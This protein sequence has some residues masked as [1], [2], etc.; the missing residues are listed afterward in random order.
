[1]DTDSS[2]EKTLPAL[3]PIANKKPHDEEKCG[4]KA[5]DEL[6]VSNGTESS[7]EHWNN[8]KINTWRFLATLWSF[9]MMGANDG[10]FGV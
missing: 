7:L 10:A 2:Q 1:M 4:M 5:E 9:W 3:L 8:P 6:P